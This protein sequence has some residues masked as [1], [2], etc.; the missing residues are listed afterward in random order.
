[1]HTSLRFTLALMATL[2]GVSSMAQEQGL[3]KPQP[4]LKETVQGMPKT[5]RQEVSVFTAT[6]MP[7]DRTVFHTHR[8][9]VTVYVMEGAFTLELEGREPITVKAGQAMVEP[10]H[11]KMT[12][13]NRSAAEPLRVVIFYVGEPNTPFLDLIP[14]SK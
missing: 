9:P 6:F 13:Y 14:A 5:D 8:S 4:V 1:M 7:G 12:G 3:A 11:V 10:P 2:F